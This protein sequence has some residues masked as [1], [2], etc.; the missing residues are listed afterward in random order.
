MRFIDR[1]AAREPI[2][3][4]IGEREFFGRS[5]F[6][7]PDVLSETAEIGKL[8]SLMLQLPLGAAE[9]GQVL[10]GMGVP[11]FESAIGNSAQI[12]LPALAND[13]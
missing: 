1:R 3:Y 10:N 12:E 11:I 8:D 7:T 13:L 2:A 6:V 4:I 9:D 5:F